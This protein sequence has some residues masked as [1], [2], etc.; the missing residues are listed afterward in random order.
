MKCGFVVSMAGLMQLSACY[1]PMAYVSD[2]A[3]ASCALYTEC[4]ALDAL[5]VDSESDCVALLDDPGF[6]CHNYDRQAAQS[7]VAYVEQST[8]EDF[9]AGK[10]SEACASACSSAFEDTGP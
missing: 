1:G 2:L 9:E 7:C 4:D 6:E 8:C 3:D 10:A 5:G